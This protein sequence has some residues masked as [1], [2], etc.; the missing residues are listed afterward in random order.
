[1]QKTA[2]SLKELAK[3]Y[4]K[5]ADQNQWVRPAVGAGLGG[6]AGALLGTLLGPKARTLKV[7]LGTLGGAGIGAGVGYKQ[8]K[9][10]TPTVTTQIKKD[11]PAVSAFSAAVKNMQPTV[12]PIKHRYLNFQP[13]QSKQSR[14]RK[15]QQ[16]REAIRQETEKEIKD[17]YW[18]NFRQGGRDGARMGLKNLSQYLVTPLATMAHGTAAGFK[19]LANY[20]PY[21]ITGNQIFNPAND[22]IPGLSQ[23][24]QKVLQTNK[25]IQDLKYQDQ[26]NVNTPIMRTI[27]KVQKGTDAALFLTTAIKGF[28]PARSALSNPISF[29]GR[30]AA[31]KSAL[32]R[33]GI[34]QKL[35]NAYA[36]DGLFFGLKI[37]YR[38]ASAGIKNTYNFVTSPKRWI[39]SLW[40]GVKNKAD[41]SI[42]WRAK[43]PF[44]PYLPAQANSAL[45]NQIYKVYKPFYLL[46]RSIPTTLKG[47]GSLSTGLHYA[48][49]ATGFL[50]PKK[51]QDA[52]NA[53]KAATRNATNALMWL[54]PRAAFNYQ[55]RTKLPGFT[56]GVLKPTGQVASQLVGLTGIMGDQEAKNKA[57]DIIFTPNPT[58]RKM[59]RRPSPA[60][61]PQQVPQGQPAVLSQTTDIPTDSVQTASDKLYNAADKIKNQK[62]HKL[63]T[64]AEEAAAG[65]IVLGNQLKNGIINTVNV[66]GKPVVK[67]LNTTEAGKQLVNKVRGVATNVAQKAPTAVTND[68]NQAINILTD[69][70]GW[71]Q[72][73]KQRGKDLPGIAKE[74]GKEKLDKTKE[75]LQKLKQIMPDKMPTNEQQAR[76]LAQQLHNNKQL[77]QILQDLTPDG[78]K[79]TRDALIG[80]LRDRAQHAPNNNTL[81]LLG[82]QNY[83]ESKWDPRLTNVIPI[84]DSP[85][86]AIAKG[87]FKDQ[88]SN[89]Y[90]YLDD[91]VSDPA[92]IEKAKQISPKLKHLKADQNFDQKRLF[93]PTVIDKTKKGGKMTGAA[94]RD[95]QNLMRIRKILSIFS[96]L[97][98]LGNKAEQ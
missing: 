77:Q 96:G 62:F 75:D 63:K 71:K 11:T 30:M 40:Q 10:Q 20:L 55:T 13:G 91:V 51:G 2:L 25:E 6:G 92:N 39:P 72:Y 58:L 56:E 38:K 23:L 5:F 18:D 36:T 35:K 16:V 47:L 97:G 98:G 88:T 45:A 26:S 4:N 89:P 68:V 37:P 28:A 43:V 82:L 73:A 8:N 69:V 86:S 22:Y 54:N 66:A 81:R 33:V 83:S 19:G 24:K 17:T 64:T 59:P 49:W 93:I 44:D 1:M 34:G 53:L 70:N 3:Q 42:N 74:K 32:Y 90:S 21:K 31:P 29:V 76:Q 57:D 67:V 65:G 79:L 60:P 84:Y 85:V 15:Y 41:K 7:L 46:D 9:K 27:D 61:Q 50:R 12:N 48:D 87:F 80:I 78:K 95:I 52:N 94:A 14:R